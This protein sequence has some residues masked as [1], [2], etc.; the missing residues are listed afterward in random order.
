MR[1]SLIE[2]FKQ[3][4]ED[5]YARSLIGKGYKARVLY[6][7]KIVKNDD[8]DEV[9]IENTTSGSYYKVITPDEQKN[10]LENGWRYGVY[11]LSL[12]NYRLKLDSIERLIKNEINH[13]NSKRVIENYKTRREQILNKYYGIKRKFNSLTKSL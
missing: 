11:V 8:T 13:K 12:S 4:Q 10:F 5:T 7:V 3:A 1:Y 6:G 9:I 2:I